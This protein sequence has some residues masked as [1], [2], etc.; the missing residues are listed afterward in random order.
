M[1]SGTGRNILEWQ[2]IAGLDISVWSRDHTIT[3]FEPDGGDD[4]AFLTVQVMQQGDTSRAIGVVLN[5][6]NF[7]RNAEFVALKVDDTIGTLGTA[8]PMAD[9][10]FT[11]VVTASMLF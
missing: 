3:D 6:C 10:D 4:V 1:D 9:G 5:C 2:C 7:G 8:A 11:L